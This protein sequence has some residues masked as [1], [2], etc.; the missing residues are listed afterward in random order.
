MFH[1]NDHIV[2]FA[3]DYV[4]QVL[5]AAEAAYVERHC[6]RC[7]SCKEAV[8][9]A[10]RRLRE[11]RS[12]PPVEASERLIRSTLQR[13]KAHDQRRSY[14]RYLVR[15]GLAVAA[16][17]AILIGLQVH[18]NRLS[19]GE[20]DVRVFGQNELEAGAKS[21]LRVQV[22]NRKT[23][24]AVSGVPVSIELSGAATGTDVQLASFT[25]D[26]RG[27]GRPTFTVPDWQEQNGVL[28]IVADVPN[29][30]QAAVSQTVTVK[31]SWKLMLSTDKPVYQP[32]QEIQV[33]A[34]ALRRA[35][36]KPVAG[37]EVV[38]SIIDP[39]G[40][41]IFKKQT[42]SSSFGISSCSCLLASEV[43]EGA[44]T[45]ICKQADTESRQ[46]VEVKKYVLP[47]FKVDVELDQPFYR[48]NQLVQGK[49]KVE[50]FFGKPVAEAP[51]KI[52]VVTAGRQQ[53][54]DGR[55]DAEGKATFS[56]PTGTNW[57]VSEME[58][59]HAQFTLNVEVQDSAKQTQTRSV[60]RLVTNE[61]LHI[62]AMPEAGQLVQDVSN[63][64]YVLVTYPD[65]RPAARKPLMV[66]S[67]SHRFQKQME[68][69]ELGIAVVEMT[70]A[71][72]QN[73][74]TVEADGQQRSFTFDVGQPTNDFLVRT[75]RAVYQGGDTLHLSFLGSPG[76]VF[77][78]LVKDRRTLLTDSVNIANTQGELDIDLGPECTGTLELWA[79]RLTPQ[80]E[81][82]R[83]SRV[84]Y[85]R[86]AEQ[87]RIATT[88]DAGEYRP[89]K[90]AK[91]RFALTDADGK[92]TPGA[93]SLAAVDEAVFAVLPQTPGM[94]Q[95]F[96]T[97]ERE[98]LEPVYRVY[99]S[100]SPAFGVGMAADQS[101]R[102]QQAVFAST[103]QSRVDKRVPPPPPGQK[104]FVVPNQ[105]APPN[106]PF[107]LDLSSFVSTQQQIQA[108]KQAANDWIGMGWIVLSIVA[109]GGAYV[110][111][112][113]IFSV[114]RVLLVTI[115][116]IAVAFTLCTFAL[117]VGAMLDWSP[118]QP[119]AVAVIAW[120]MILAILFVGLGMGPAL[121]FWR[122]QENGQRS[123]RH[124]TRTPATLLTV[125][126]LYAFLAASVVLILVGLAVVSTLGVG[127]ASRKMATF[128]AVGRQ[129]AAEPMM[130]E[131][132]PEAKETVLAMPTS[133]PNPDVEHIG[134]DPNPQQ[135]PAP[136][137]VRVRE[138]FPET[139]LWKPEFIT[140]EQGRATLDL[141]LADSITTWRL[142]ASAI[143][144]DGRLGSTTAPIKV[145]Q[146]FFVDLNLPVSLTR[147]D[148]VS[149]PVAIYN[150]LAKPQTIE[151]ELE[152]AS[153]FE[154]TGPAN[155]RVE[156]AAN[157]V[158]SI[159]YRIRVQKAG[160]RQLQVTARA[161]QL[162]DAIRREIEVVPDGRR[163]EQFASDRLTGDVRQTFTIAADAVPDSSKILVKVYPGVYAQVIDGID[164]MLQMPHGCF[165]QTSSST[166]P[167]LLVLDYLRKTNGNPQALARAEQY[168]HLGYQRLLTFENKG[169]GFDWWGHGPPVVWLTAYGLLEFND[170]SKVY[171][172]DPNVISRT[173]SWLLSRQAKDGTWSDIGP[174]HGELI[175]GMPNPRFLLTCYVTWALAESGA[176]SPQL[177]RSVQF[178]RQ[179][180][181]QERDG[182]ALALAANALAAWDRQHESTH[183]ILDKLQASR[184]E[185]QDWKATFYSS[186]GATLNYAHGDAANVETTALAALAMLKAGG[187][188]Q[189]VNEA[190]TFL[191]KSK[192]PNGTWASTAATVLS[193]KAL[194]LGMETPAASGKSGG[195]SITVNGKP[196]GAGKV[197]DFN[198]EVVQFFDLG[199]HAKSGENEI[200]IRSHG[201]LAMMYQIVVRHHEPWSKLAPVA[202]PTLDLQ[203]KYDRTELTPDDRVWARA[204]LRN[205]S[206][207]RANM[208]ML[209]LGIPPGFNV[210]RSRLDELVA[211]RR[212]ARYSITPRQIIVYLVG[213]DAGTSFEMDYW[214]RPRFTMKAKTPPAVAYEY[215]TPSNRVT[216]PP[217]EMTVWERR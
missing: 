172:V 56:F 205:M 11:L 99:P 48:P 47:K 192:Y 124:P 171:P 133:A 53:R 142:G 176:R 90:N 132:L 49:V 73:S 156:L 209:E 128:T 197:N 104:Q 144:T 143:T 71:G 216:A 194:V 157:E 39:K 46:R 97:V 214:L 139:L 31:R 111:L 126:R 86:P 61:S 84:L 204:T 35:D 92:P 120:G 94:E 57:N 51:V 161:D 116:V 96:Y 114:K 164:G 21:S 212:I 1:D 81:W 215:Y 211:G 52:D 85:V 44:Y 190:L 89:G 151:I 188:G 75:D 203:V 135:V 125:E 107:S 147:G 136:A 137:P 174:T 102:F 191:A 123:V 72:W 149:V 208:V 22:L 63:R 127:S 200:I 169:G 184:Q 26:A 167:N 130:D 18:F 64:I 182:Y 4:H 67:G 24:A 166:Y 177:E 91:V 121:L 9:A 25:T 33:R 148:E 29:A 206:K 201:N 168:L 155:Q 15:A 178:I 32:G 108:R 213:V 179:W 180:A 160:R 66:S 65:G 119:V 95:T 117:V 207:D 110:Y 37:Q 58:Q 41:V 78:D 36:R 183:A 43:I 8:D 100:W 186:R 189:S 30:G 113:L 131:A 69:D 12:V 6:E 181:P 103:A 54:L 134:V 14:R 80:G 76:T 62:E 77:V 115:G 153:W 98:L 154:R 38:F 170:M 112:M 141:S 27:T 83:K 109:V 88:L 13:V 140:D 138:H 19:A 163:V 145:F 173:Q 55:T 187:H 175:A 5:S 59:R 79:Y 159:N 193:L 16:S 150:Y 10:E 34:L 50:Y 101:D 60:S 105:K 7:A 23:G 199:E 40:N 45:V 87:L 68:T 129:L 70:P 17:V 106:W 93:L 118:A 3:D 152:N 146:P 20:F 2:D 122:A 28:R 217:V 195:F 82:L 158:R 42:T 196:A 74:F 185:R 162:S 202:K 210:D 165:E 198:A